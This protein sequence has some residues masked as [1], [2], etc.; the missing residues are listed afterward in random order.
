MKKLLYRKLISC[1]MVVLIGF[2][3]FAFTGCGSQRHPR[4][5]PAIGNRLEIRIRRDY[6][7]MTRLQPSDLD[8]EWVRIL[9]YYGTFNRASVVTI[10]EGAVGM[11]SWRATV[12]G[13]SFYYPGVFL[14]IW[15]WR[16]GNFYSLQEAYDQNFLTVADLQVIAERHETRKQSL[17]ED[18]WGN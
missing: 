4:S 3:V 1:V 8:L 7:E 9:R 16:R 2:S 5:D 12:A 15:V 13:I 11:D 6:V 18:L 14:I 10:S 17:D